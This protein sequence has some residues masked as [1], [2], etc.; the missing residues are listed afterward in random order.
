MSI[1]AKMDEAIRA[2]LSSAEPTAAARDVLAERLRQISAEGWTPK[3]DDEE[4]PFGQ[5]ALAAASYAVHA[6]EGWGDDLFTYANA[7]PPNFWPW[8]SWWKPRDQRRDLVRAGALI[9]AEIERL[10][11]AAAAKAQ[12]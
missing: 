11:R 6:G 12:G 8:G 1:E 2:A 7:P 3:H 4:H 9:L 5:L 10:D